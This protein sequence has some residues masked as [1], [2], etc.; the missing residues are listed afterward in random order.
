CSL[1]DVG[2]DGGIE[3]LVMEFLDGEPLSERLARGRAGSP[4]KLE[5]T[6]EIAIA[7]AGALDAA[8]RAGVVHRDLKPGNIV[9]T[10][11]GPKLL[12][13]GLA[14]VAALSQAGRTLT[15]PPTV[16]SPLTAHGTLIGTI[17]YMEPE[18][19]EGEQADGRA[20]VFAF[21]CVLY[22]MLTARKAFE[23]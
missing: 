8:H 5:E 7:I 22:E 16:T 10:R 1:Y 3:Y 11:S 21:G 4:L 6:L 12:D 15:E 9:L 18:Q 19:L 23:G 14:R 13:F 17:Q 2:H 20:D